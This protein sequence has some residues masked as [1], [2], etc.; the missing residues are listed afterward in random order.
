MIQLN[1]R[2]FLSV[3]LNGSAVYKPT[4]RVSSLSS[5]C[6]RAVH[7]VARNLLLQLPRPTHPSW[8][9]RS[10]W[11]S[12]CSWISLL[13]ECCAS[14]AF[15]MFV[16]CRMFSCIP[17]TATDVL[18]CQLV[19]GA[20]DWLWPWE[21]SSRQAGCR[22]LG[23]WRESRVLSSARPGPSRRVPTVARQPLGSAT[24]VRPWG[25]PS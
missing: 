15:F 10:L 11:S 5:L 18:P 25:S 22:R 7:H 8:E 1:K 16:F 19:C 14:A 6:S 21:R 20:M 23:G 3:R 17:I 4:L 24:S 12:P 9:L 2:S 13:L